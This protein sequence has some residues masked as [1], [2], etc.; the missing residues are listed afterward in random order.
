MSTYLLPPP[1]DTSARHNRW[2]RFLNL[3]HL[4]QDPGVYMGAVRSL[5]ICRFRKQQTSHFAAIIELGARGVAVV[6]L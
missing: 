3:P 5:S 2:R 6:I 1:Q 4:A